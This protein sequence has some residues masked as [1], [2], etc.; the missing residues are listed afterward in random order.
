MGF[1]CVLLAVVPVVLLV[2]AAI[3]KAAVS[4]TNSILG[5]D[6][7]DEYDFYA[8]DDEDDFLPPPPR[9]RSGGPVPN[10]SYGKGMLTIF[11]I[12][13]VNSVVG[14]AFWIVILGGA[15]PNAREPEPLAQ[16]ACALIGFLI[17][18]V[19]TGGTL[20]TSFPRACLVVLFELLI[21]AAV[22]VVIA[23]VLFVL[24]VAV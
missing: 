2:G 20:P 4:I 22:G 17:A 15:N 1:L 7:S 10:P 8:D 13:M 3:L 12:A 18:A 16:L 21:C 23:A 6:R 5:T 11:A 14:F 19:L 24:R 9:S